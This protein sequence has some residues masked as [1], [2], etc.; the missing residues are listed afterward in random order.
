MASRTT[1]S[2]G[3]NLL[4][5]TVALAVLSVLVLATGTLLMH[6]M[7]G[8]DQAEE[9]ACALAAVKGLLAEAKTSDPPD[10]VPRKRALNTDA[11]PAVLRGAKAEAAWDRWEPGILRLAVALTWESG[12]GAR[13]RI[14]LTT[15]V[16]GGEEP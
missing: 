4:E 11:L 13:R 3:F 6:V 2:R 16:P 9:E 7:R 15:L 14:E 8:A 1:P 12:R 10:A 5:F